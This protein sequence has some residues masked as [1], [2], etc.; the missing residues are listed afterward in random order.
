MTDVLGAR[1]KVLLAQ[2]HKIVV[3]N[4][5]IS[6]CIKFRAKIVGVCEICNRDFPICE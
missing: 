6:L 4:V 1:A 3:M 5:F 2:T